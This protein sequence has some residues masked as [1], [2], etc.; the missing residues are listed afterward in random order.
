MKY[1]AIGFPDT[2]TT[3]IDMVGFGATPVEFKN[4]EIFTLFKVLNRSCFDIVTPIIKFIRVMTQV[5]KNFC[6]V[7]INF[8]VKIGEMSTPVMITRIG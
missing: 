5:I 2:H 4:Q 8:F 7:S 6:Q 3:I 1:N